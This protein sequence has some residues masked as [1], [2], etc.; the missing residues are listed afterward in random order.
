MSSIDQS[1]RGG[2]KRY[3]KWIPYLL[4]LPIILLSSWLLIC[5][6]GNVFRGSALSITGNGCSYFFMCE[7]TNLQF[8]V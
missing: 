2:G 1:I 5:P 8:L 6:V 4:M 3:E 7:L